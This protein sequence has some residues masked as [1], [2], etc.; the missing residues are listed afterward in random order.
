MGSEHIL[1]RIVSS[2]SV[3]DLNL[4]APAIFRTQI[5]QIQTILSSLKLGSEQNGKFEHFLSFSL[6]N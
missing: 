5:E 2:T 3:Q 4:A 1:R 6:R